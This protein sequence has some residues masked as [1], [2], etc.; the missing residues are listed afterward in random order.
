MNKHT[1]LVWIVVLVLG[2]GF[3]FLFWGKP[4]GIN[5]AIYLTACLLGGSLVLLANDLKPAIKS[6]LL[7]LPF[8]FF[9]IITVL[10]KEPMTMILSIMGALVSLGLL[11]V[12]YLGGRWTRYS[13]FDYF[14]KFF[15]LIGNIIVLPIIFIRDRKINWAGVRRLPIKPVTRGLL[16]AIPVVV[17]FAVLL[18]AGD[19]VFK[20]QIIN[21]FDR[22]DL[23][24]IPEYI[25]RLIIIL[26]WAYI[27]M[28]VYLYAALKS[29][30]ERLLG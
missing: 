21:F 20:Q 15:L 5:F 6:L 25:A 1:N 16:I 30:D 2:W 22:I 12:T 24:R 29:T 3:D 13:L 9:A 26:F 23:G 18:A 4:V 11:A 19:I 10:R 28:G 17:F 27:L 14:K 8:V 7:V